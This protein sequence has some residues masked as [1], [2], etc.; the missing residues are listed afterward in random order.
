M[1]QKAGPSSLTAFAEAAGYDRTTLNRTVR[2][3]EVAGLVHSSPGPDR[4]MRIISVT[5]EAKER[6]RSA[7]I[8]WEKAQQRISD[9]L[10]PD[11]EALFATLD[12]IEELRP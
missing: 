11:Q 9:A 10:G 6:M 4:R 12:K 7:Q 8:Y 3:L 5:Q 1:L 2:P